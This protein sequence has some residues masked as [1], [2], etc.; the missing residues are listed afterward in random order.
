FGRKPY[1]NHSRNHSSLSHD[2]KPPSGGFFVAR[3]RPELSGHAAATACTSISTFNASR[4]TSKMVARLSMLGLPLADSM[5]CRLLAGFSVSVASCSKPTVAFT[6]SRSIM[7]AVSGSPFRNS[8]AASS[9][10]ARAKAGSRSTRAATVCLKSR[11]S[12]MGSSLLSTTLL[13]RFLLLQLCLPRLV[14]N[15]QLLG[16]VDVALLPPFRAATEKDDEAFPVAGEVNPVAGSPIDDVLAKT[17]EPFH[18]GGVALAQPCLR[19]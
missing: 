2:A 3:W 8:V 1:P 17:S 11:V 4:R 10:I 6:R 18:A 5:R 15:E 13:A 7:R 9:S 14:R 12:A 19:G 16:P